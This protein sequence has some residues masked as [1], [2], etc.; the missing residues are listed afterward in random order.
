VLKTIAGF[1]NAHGGTLMIG[2]DDDGKVLGLAA[3]GFPKED[4][5]GLHLVNLIRDRIGDIFLPYVHPHF[6]DEDDERVLVIRCEKGPKSAFVKDGSVQ[7]FYVRGA[8]ATVELSG[9]SL[10]DYVKAHFK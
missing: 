6:E 2:V 5:M 3:D 10:M 9:S 8:N 7:R 4:Q 1:L